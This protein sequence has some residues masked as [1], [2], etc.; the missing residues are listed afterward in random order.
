MRPPL[1]T[2]GVVL[3][4]S[5]DFFNLSAEKDVISFM[6]YSSVRFRCTYFPGRF[7]R[8]LKG[9]ILF[10]HDIG[11]IFGRVFAV[12]KAHKHAIFPT[13]SIV[14]AAPMC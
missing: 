12:C 14:A 3:S 13:N 8:V 9:N 10:K 5:V 11:A 7:P 2:K 1:V 6:Q 4:E